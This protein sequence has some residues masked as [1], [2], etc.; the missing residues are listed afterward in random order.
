MSKIRISTMIVFVLSVAN[1]W[2]AV[3]M[4]DF[5]RPD[6]ELGNDWATVTDGTIEVKIVDNEVLIAGEQ[7][8]DWARSGLSRAVEDE[9]RISFDF[10]TDDNFNVH[11]RIDDAD[12]GTY[13]DVYAWP[14]GPFS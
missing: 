13:I 2:G 5:N 12:T 9:T 10:K 4:D 3:F 14:D 11:I 8:T 6:G 1:A 7:A